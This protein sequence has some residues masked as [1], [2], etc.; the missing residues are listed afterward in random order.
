MNQINI[1]LFIKRY[2]RK[3]FTMPWITIFAPV[4]LLSF[5]TLFIHFRTIALDK[6]IDIINKD[7]LIIYDLNEVWRFVLILTLTNF[8]ANFFLEKTNPRYKYIFFYL[9]LFLVIIFGLLTI[10][11]Y[12]SL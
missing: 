7:K 10:I 6:N 5:F 11:S 1:I 4:F 9:N 12:F 3:L 8:T 2:L